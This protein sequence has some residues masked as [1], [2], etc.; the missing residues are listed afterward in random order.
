MTYP[1]DNFDQL[2]IC[3]YLGKNRDSLSIFA[4]ILNAANSGTSKTRIMIE[5]NLSFSL[6]EKYLPVALKAG[7]VQILDNKY[8]T[9]EHGYSFLREYK[10]F[11]NRYERAQQILNS[12]EL[13]RERLFKFCRELERQDLLPLREFQDRIC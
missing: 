7:L 2:W 13:E 4:A 12:L 11:C 9:T 6:L 8:S 5:A 1:L 3:F 10:C